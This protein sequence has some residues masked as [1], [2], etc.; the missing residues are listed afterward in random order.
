MVSSNKGVQQRYSITPITRGT[1]VIDINKASSCCL[2][3]AS[4]PHGRIKNESPVRPFTSLHFVG[5]EMLV[6]PDAGI[7]QLVGELSGWV[8]GM[9][10]HVACWQRTQELL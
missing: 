3:V 7:W 10:G 2:T 8:L 9:V 4:L 1:P 6:K 5:I